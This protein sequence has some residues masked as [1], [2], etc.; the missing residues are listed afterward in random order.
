MYT[1]KLNQLDGLF[2]CEGLNSDIIRIESSRLEEYIS[3]INQNKINKLNITDQIGNIKLYELP[4]LYFLVQCPNIEELNIQSN[5]I[6][7]YTGIYNL[8]KLLTLSIDDPLNKIDLLLLPSLQTL[9][10][11]YNE[12]LQDFTKCEK[13]KELLLIGYRVKIANLSHFQSLSNIETLTLT[14]T[15]LQNLSGIKNLTKL[16]YIELNY[17]RSLLD[18]SELAECKNLEKIQMSNCKKIH[19]LTQT[20]ENIPTLKKIILS[21]CGEI[22]NLE[23]VKKLPNL[24]FISFVGTKVISG[25]LNPIVGLEYAGFDN[26]K[27]YNYRNEQINPEFAKRAKESLKN[28]WKNAN[29]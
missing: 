6:E 26:K 12:N 23:F 15:N 19:N 17:N 16:K 27:H 8:S 3:Y 22:Q 20:L 21:D 11:S 5:R 28:A 24:K 4:D 13:L 10:A 1:I 25:D 29:K 18:I 14:Q 7:N 2:F 9:R